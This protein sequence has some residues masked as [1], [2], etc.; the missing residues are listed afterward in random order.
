M[1]YL[2]FTLSMPGCNSWNGRWSGEG[3]DYNIVTKVATKK[4]QELAKALVSIGYFD[5]K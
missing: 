3:R 5:Q 1:K 4:K 2:K